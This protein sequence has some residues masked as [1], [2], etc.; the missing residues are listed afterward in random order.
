MK[1]PWADQYI[2]PRQGLAWKFATDPTVFRRGRETVMAQ[3]EGDLRRMDVLQEAL[4]EEVHQRRLAVEINPSSNLLVGNLADIA[5][6][7]FWLLRPPVEKGRPGLRVC[8]GSDDPLTF[9]THT[10]LEYQL[11]EDALLAG[12]VGQPQVDDWLEQARKTGLDYR[13]TSAIDDTLWS[14]I[15]QESELMYAGRQR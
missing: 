8:I 6:H 3:T 5:H 2:K 1:E 9:A 10:A 7:P 4:R 13:F 15:V 14:K 12:G 11:L